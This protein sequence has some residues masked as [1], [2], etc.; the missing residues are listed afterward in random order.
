LTPSAG[1][2]PTIAR[3]C[4]ATARPFLASSRR[5]RSPGISTPPLPTRSPCY[6]RLVLDGSPGGRRA[7][8]RP[9]ASVPVPTFVSSLGTHVYERRNQRDTSNSM[10]LVRL[11]ISRSYH[12]LAVT[13]LATSNPPP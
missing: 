1:S 7:P 3:A 13:L 9:R 10:I 11:W 12:G 6:E 8:P 2:Q 5:A 4:C